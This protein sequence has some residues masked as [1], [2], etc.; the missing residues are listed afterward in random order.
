MKQ[1]AANVLQRT[2]YE[3]KPIKT[4]QS[5]RSTSTRRHSNTSQA[6]GGNFRANLVSSIASQNLLHKS[7]AGNLT[8]GLSDA[9][10]ITQTNAYHLPSTRGPTDAVICDEP[11]A[12]PLEPVGLDSESASHMKQSA[13][14]DLLSSSPNFNFSPFDVQSFEDATPDEFTPINFLHGIR[15]INYDFNFSDNSGEN[16]IS[17]DNENQARASN[18]VWTKPDDTQSVSN[19]SLDLD[20]FDPL[21]NKE[22]AT[23]LAMS[24]KP[25]AI[26]L[27][28][29][30]PTTLIE[31]EDSPNQV[32]L[33]SPLKPTATDYKGFSKFDIPTISCNTGDF[34]SLNY[35]ETNAPGSSSKS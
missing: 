4:L 14:N 22:I 8:F 13:S 27:I 29:T 35:D 5:L 20:E 28:G 34:S 16:S 11:L 12:K 17:E 3:L 19:L 2:P 33:P 18:F 1:S 24:T 10:S 31:S 30:K 7:N 6:S 25:S 26:D 15:N 9:S 21:R 32:L 23:V